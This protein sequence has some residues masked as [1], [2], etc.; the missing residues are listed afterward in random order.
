MKKEIEIL[1]EE[2]AKILLL[3]LCE[4]GWSDS[5]PDDVIE[6]IEDEFG[7]VF[8]GESYSQELTED[9]KSKVTIIDVNTH[10]VSIPS[11]ECS[12][13]ALSPEMGM[14]LFNMLHK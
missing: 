12:S 4:Y 1:T 10:E 8:K 3:K 5:I 11:S 2:Q 9:E 6:T 7:I 14:K 13:N